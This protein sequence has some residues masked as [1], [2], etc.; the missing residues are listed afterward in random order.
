ML[1]SL[2]VM[3]VN[4]WL[5]ASKKKNFDA[6]EVFTSM[7]MLA[8]MTASKPMMFIARITLRIM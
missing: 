3:H 6:S 8:V 1:H 7:T 4:T 2:P 5:T